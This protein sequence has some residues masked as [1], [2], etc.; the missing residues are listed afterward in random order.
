M[1]L[2][3][4]EIGFM[5]R[6]F[7]VG[8]AVSI[9]LGPIG[10]MIVQRTLTRGHLAGF[11][12]GVG[13]AVSDLL[14]ALIAGFGFSLVID[15]ID[16][17]RERLQVSGGAVLLA[18]GIYTFLQ[19]PIRQIRQPRKRNTNYWQ[20]VVSTF[21]LTVSNPLAVFSFVVIFTSFDVFSQIQATHSM[22]AVLAGVFLGAIS[23]W[24][25]LTLLVGLFRRF[26][27]V[28]HLWWINKISGVAIALIA[29][30]IIIFVFL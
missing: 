4:G 11:F 19:N 8:I 28:R 23:W 27:N 1:D 20:D 30:G 2:I 22:Y 16:L 21:F 3:F 5:L 25:V 6:G 18:F 24:M 29:V 17:H 14:Y 7:L 26:I 13:A 15:F 10:V 12:S 9:P